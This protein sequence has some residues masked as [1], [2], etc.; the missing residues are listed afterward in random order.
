M[1][2]FLNFNTKAIKATNNFNVKEGVG[3]AGTGE[4]L[5]TLRWQ[6]SYY[7]VKVNVG[8]CQGQGQVESNSSSHS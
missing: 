2:W 5:V 3:G 7:L 8:R 6:S 1:L 4:P